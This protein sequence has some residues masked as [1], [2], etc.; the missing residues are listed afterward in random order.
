ML[1]Y[2]DR[3]TGRRRPNPVV[4]SDLRVDYRP[5]NM[6]VFRHH[7]RE[8]IEVDVEDVEGRH[9]APPEQHGLGDEP[10]TRVINVLEMRRLNDPDYTF[11]PVRDIL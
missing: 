1:E 10:L 11:T 9:G 2:L 8:T 7:T 3:L 5:R 4:P 6:R